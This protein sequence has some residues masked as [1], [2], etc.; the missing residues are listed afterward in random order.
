MIPYPARVEPDDG[1]LSLDAGL[2]IHAGPGASHEAHELGRAIAAR[3]GL[4]LSVRDSPTGDASEPR[5]QAIRL[6]LDAEAGYRSEA[7]R[8]RTDG[9]GAEIV[10]ATNAGLFYGTQTLAQALETTTDGTGATWHLPHL[11]IEDAPR[12]TY[13]GMMLDVARHFFSVEDVCAVIDR[14]ASLKLNHLH[15]HLSDDQGWRLQIDAWPRLTTPEPDAS[16][17]FYSKAD[18]RRIVE[19]AATRHMTVVPEI[20]MP[21]HTHAVGIAYPE[22]VEAPVIS[23]ELRAQVAELGQ[24][25]PEAGVPFTGWAV[26]F[27]SLRIGDQTVD[28]FVRDV[29]RELGELTPGPY[30]HIGGDE[31]LGTAPADFAAFVSLAARVVR[32]VGK[33]P[34]TWQEA[35]AVAG[36]P[37][38]TIGQYWGFVAPQEGHDDLARDFV[39]NGGRVI[40]SPADATYLD[41]KPDADST[42]GLTW[43]NGPTSLRRA[44]EW[45]PLA[46]VEGLT[47]HD[48]LGVEA[49]LWTETVE[50]LADIDAL[51]FPRIA[52]AA[53]IAWSSP[54]AMSAART[55]E[56]FRERV[57]ALAPLWRAAGIGGAR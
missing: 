15:L 20:D 41:M 48:I 57:D 23:E 25:L 13:R 42:L 50:T 17:S 28:R 2:V 12:F 38:G 24:T 53:E 47:E 9:S 21:G 33:V 31:A 49:A 54:P 35:G 22:L 55:W 16:T 6:R 27:S 51:V 11:S 14:A 37:V 3:T 4:A 39:R 5:P 32:D 56:S 40:L 7:Y 1:A 52:A 46:V 34:I 19:H 26:G 10:A 45:E 36:L 18:Y 43:A 8:L 29:I 30:L 44:Y